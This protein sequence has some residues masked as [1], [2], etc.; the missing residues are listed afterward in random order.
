[1]QTAALLLYFCLTALQAGHAVH[2]DEPERVADAIATFIRRFRWERR[3]PPLPCPGQCRVR[4][5]PARCAA[6]PSQAQTRPGCQQSPLLLPSL[7]SAPLNVLTGSGSPP[8]PSPGQRRAS[9]PCCL[10]PWA[11]PSRRRQGG[12]RRQRRLDGWRSRRSERRT[13]K[14]WAHQGLVGTCLCQPDFGRMAVLCSP[15]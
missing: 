12:R 7:D 13:S 3:F 2:E 4:R 6:L 9:S 11:P 10:C 5:S 14:L 8:W 15:L 1:M